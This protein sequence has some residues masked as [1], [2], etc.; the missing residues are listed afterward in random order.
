M[1]LSM[2]GSN[3]DTLSLASGAYDLADLSNVTGFEYVE[4]VGTAGTPISFMVPNSLTLGSGD[5]N[6]IIFSVA[7]A[8][9]AGVLIDASAVAT[10][11]IE[12]D[13]NSSGLS[14]TV[15]NMSGNDTIIG[16]QNSDY[17][18][19]GA[20]DDIFIGELGDDVFFGGAGRDTFVLGSGSI[21][22]IKDFI[23][24][25]DYINVASFTS[26]NWILD[27]NGQSFDSTPTSVNATDKVVQL[28]ATGS[29]SNT[30]DVDSVSDVAAAFSS[31][32]YAV[33][34][35]GKSI[36][37]SGRNDAA[38]N[39][40]VWL[41]DSAA[42]GVGANVTQ[43]DVEQIGVM[44]NVE[45]DNLT[46]NNFI[47]TNNDVVEFNNNNGDQSVAGAASFGD[48]ATYRTIT[49][50]Q[51]SAGDK[52]EM[53]GFSFEPGRGNSTSVVSTLGS[54]GAIDSTSTILQ[55]TDSS[56]SDINLIGNFVT[57]LESAL[58]LSSLADQ[59]HMIAIF[60]ASDIDGD[61]N[62]KQSWVALYR[63]ETV[64]DNADLYNFQIIGLVSQANSD[65]TLDHTNFVFY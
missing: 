40:Y 5:G 46:S 25:D 26:A 62:T 22:E 24:T 38:A 64:G 31:G 57:G 10:G 20:G 12:I 49:D 51:S 23:A 35:N 32:L 56:Y 50:F 3:F 7:Q 17:L 63:N 60:G 11:F 54:N 37:I 4:F 9:T 53:I 41:V 14:T 15:S 44:R 2:A 19:A 65:A 8:N 16:S 29:T 61:V 28:W 13:A 34:T 47:F 18:A 27:S 52:I 36:V 45:I 55:I 48:D 39:A 58:D 33:D 21:D 42:D 1:I 6:A 59:D 43:A 30:S